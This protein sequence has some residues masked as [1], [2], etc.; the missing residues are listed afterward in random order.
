MKKNK[1]NTVIELP[2]EWT[3]QIMIYKQKEEME[4]GLIQKSTR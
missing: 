3:G 4:E 1:N 2:T